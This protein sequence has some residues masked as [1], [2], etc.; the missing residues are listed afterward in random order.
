ME[1]NKKSYYAIIPANVR[2]DK[3]LKAN[4]KLLYGELTALSN[5]EGYCWAGNGYFAPLYDVSKETISRWVKQLKEFNY[6]RI[7]Y[8]YKDD[9]KEIEQRRIY[10]DNSIP[11]DE[12]VNTPPQKGH[13]PMTKKSY[14]H[15]KKV[16]V[17]TTINTIN[18]NTKNKDKGASLSLINE[19]LNCWTDNG[20]A[21]HS[22]TT[23]QNNMKPKELKIL[24]SYHTDDLKQAIHNYSVVCNSDEYFWSWS[25]W[26]LLEF[27][28]RGLIKFLPEADPL[29]R[30]KIADSEAAEDKK[31]DDNL[32]K[33]VERV[34]KEE[35]AKKHGKN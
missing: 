10:I 27:L 34:E 6:I 18:N 14:P 17:N 28:S 4:A 3:R 24:K 12:N 13:T 33:I 2:Y 22:L 16:K 23:I 7:E 26:T 20:L 15:D 19:I 11:D 31:Y 5:Q 35:A 32:K 1:E 8:I 21:R 30:F 29:T 9:S 25:S